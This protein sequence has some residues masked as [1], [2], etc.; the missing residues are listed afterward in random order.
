MKKDEGVTSE[1]MKEGKKCVKEEVGGKERMRVNE[2]VK[3]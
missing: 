3:G 1:N 2:G